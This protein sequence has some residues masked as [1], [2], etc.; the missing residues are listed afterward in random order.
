M[1]AQGGVWGRFECDQCGWHETCDRQIAEDIGLE[2]K[3]HTPERKLTTERMVKKAARIHKGKAPDTTHIY[4][5]KWK[6]N[7]KEVKFLEVSI[8]VYTTYEVT[9]FSFAPE[10][11]G[12]FPFRQNIAVVSQLERAMLEKGDMDMPDG[13][14]KFDDLIQIQ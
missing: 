11:N 2:W 7:P 14:G 5:V 4:A 8:E 10:L 3:L 9:P 13:W 12:G 1:I 6:K